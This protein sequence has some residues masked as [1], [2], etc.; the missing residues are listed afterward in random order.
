MVKALVVLNPSACDFEAQRRWPYLQGILG[1]SSK[2]E[3]LQTDPDDAVT[4][5]K[6]VAALS[7]EVYERVIAIGGDGTVHIVVNAMGAVE[8]RPNRLG[9]IPFGTANDVAKSLRLPVGDL[10]ALGQAAMSH[11]FAAFDVGRARLRRDEGLQERLFVD[12]VTLGMDADILAARG[13]FRSLLKGYASY[14]PALAER[15]L[16]QHSVDIRATCDDEVIDAR[17]FNLVI[18][19]APIYAGVL[20]LPG[21]RSDDGKLDLYLFNRREYVS[22][23]ISFAIKQADILQLGVSELLEDLTENQRSFQGRTISVR[24]AYPRKVQVDGEIFGATDEISCDVAFT[25]E[26]PIGPAA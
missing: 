8:N 26:V 17:V 15:A 16:E 1:P 23:V 3:V 25:L 2:I 10:D 14:V 13:K 21:S 19:N 9:V 11:T 18:N 7:A 12:S 6:V 20:E 4:E 5:A 22:K 24:S